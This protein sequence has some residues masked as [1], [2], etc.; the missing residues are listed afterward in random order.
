MRREREGR[1]DLF[2]VGDPFAPFRGFRMMPSLFGGRDP[3]N[4]PFFTRPFDSISE[5]RGPEPRNSAP[6]DVFH[7]DRAKGLVIEEVTSDG[8][9]EEETHT[10]DEKINHQNHTGSNKEPSVEHPDDD[11]SY[12]RESEDLN[13][14]N[15]YNRTQRA[16][17]QAHSF[18]SQT[19]K[20]TYG[21]VNGAYYSSMRTRRTAA[22]GV[23][24]E[25]SKEAD[26]TTG[27]AKHR[28]SRGIHDKG[29]SVTK[30]LNSDG[31]VDTVQTLHN[32]N[33]DQLRGFEEAWN[34]N[35]KG[36][37]RGWTN[38][39]STHENAASSCS[40]RKPG[41]T[42]G[43]RALPSSEQDKY[44]GGRGFDSE[45]GTYPSGGRTKKVVRINIE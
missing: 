44:V 1:N 21:G 27:Q 11:D 24:I 9:G 4:D 19:C 39:L 38:Q 16:E 33:E 10:V 7:N 6:A 30:K 35:A 43:G 12:E 34:S 36:K 20:V 25:E 45:H 29:H 8:E 23:V 31:K 5:S 37:L 2:G 26:K 3:F 13:G 14:R 22:D 15:D 32:L 40:G 18:N 17:P 28:I 41:E 42:W